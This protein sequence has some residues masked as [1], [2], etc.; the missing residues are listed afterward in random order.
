MTH[1]EYADSLR[2]IADW[3]E[4]HP[5]I[6]V[7]SNEAIKIFAAGDK[8]RLK[9]CARALGDSEKIHSLEFNLFTLRKRFGCLYV[10][11][12]ISRS[13]VCKRIVKG[14]KPVPEVTIPAKPEQVIPAHEEEIVE[15]DCSEPLL[16]TEAVA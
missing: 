7:P 4:V 3:V 8:D 1:K 14:T 11:V 10:D 2:L 5:E 16:D 9:L 13:A 15:W 12:I 6:P